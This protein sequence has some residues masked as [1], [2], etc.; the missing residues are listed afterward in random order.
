VYSTCKIRY[1][2]SKG[3]NNIIQKIQFEIDSYDIF[4][5]IPYD[6]FDNIKEMDKNSFA[7]VYSA[8]WK[9]SPLHY[10]NKKVALKYTNIL[11]NIIGEFNKV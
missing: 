5:W 7:K 1:S 8:L 10:N 2:H 11:Q 3:I 4:G 9:D 6:Q